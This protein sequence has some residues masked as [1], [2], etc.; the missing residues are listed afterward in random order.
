MKH[1]LVVLS[2]IVFAILFLGLIT[3]SGIVMLVAIPPVL[4][5]LGGYLLRPTDPQLTAERTVHPSRVLPGQPITVTVNVTNHGEALAE[6]IISDHVP[7]GLRVVDGSPSTATVL[8]QGAQATLSY[9]I[10]AARGS[11]TFDAVT[12]EV[13][14]SLPVRSQTLELPAEHE[15]ITLPDH[16]ALSRIPIAARRTLVFAGTNPAR[17]G[18]DGTEFF[19]IRES[20]GDETVRHLNWRAT[21]RTGRP[22]VTLFQQ[23]RVADVAVMLDCRA[24]AYP[25]GVRL[26]ESAAVAAASMADTIIDSG[27]R[28]GYLAYGLMVDWLAPGFGK[29]QRQKILTRIARSRLGDSVVFS[30]L[31]SI[32][33]RLFP[34]GSQIVVISPL[35][36]DDVPALE[37]MLATGYA[38]LVVS[39][40]PT[41]ALTDPEA[42]ADVAASNHLIRLERA[43]LIRRLRHAGVA[44]IDWDTTEALELAV[45]RSLRGI[46]AAWRRRGR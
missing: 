9:T 5:L 10:E 15:L 24:R 32:P 33:E 22:Y 41:P 16:R 6:V 18:G 1:Q 35:G 42:H 30:S 40:D 46:Q 14:G 38:V 21:A 27:N 37:R 23:E 11:Y 13:A 12:A 26:F 44:V 43:V 36:R 39:P 2:V 25:G 17:T 19:D 34:Q 29:I 28:V 45:A 31:S 8:E 3:V 4:Y 7:H 20:R